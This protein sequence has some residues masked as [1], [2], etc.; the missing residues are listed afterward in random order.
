LCLLLLMCLSLLAVE[1]F[2]NKIED[3]SHL[4]ALI[5]REVEASRPQMNQKRREPAPYCVVP[6]VLSLSIVLKV[7]TCCSEAA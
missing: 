2:L 5:R 3:D 7:P 4:E 1:G 6:F